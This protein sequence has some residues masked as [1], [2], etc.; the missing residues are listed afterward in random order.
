MPTVLKLVLA[1]LICIGL[2]TGIVYAFKWLL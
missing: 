2:I 1:C